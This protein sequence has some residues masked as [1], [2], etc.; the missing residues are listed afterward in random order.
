MTV[1][2]LFLVQF[3][4]FNVILLRCGSHKMYSQ[5][6]LMTWDEVELD[7]RLKREV[8]KYTPYDI[9]NKKYRANIPRV[10]P[11]PLTMKNLT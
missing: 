2:L 5:V 9:Q 4:I 3:P 10:I 11:V 8:N 7:V 1:C 6:M